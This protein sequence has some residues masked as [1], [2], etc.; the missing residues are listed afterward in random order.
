MPYITNYNY[1]QIVNRFNFYE[2]VLEGDVYDGLIT[3]NTTDPYKTGKENKDWKDIFSKKERNELLCFMRC[4][5]NPREIME[6][7][8]FKKIKERKDSGRYV[9]EEKMPCY[10][11][12]ADCEYL[13]S[14]YENYLLPLEIQEADEEK[15]RAYR[16]WFKQNRYLLDDGEYEKL[17]YRIQM[18]WGINMDLQDLKGLHR[19]N[20]GVRI[21]ENPDLAIIESDIIKLVGEMYD[22][23]MQ[24]VRYRNIIDRYGK[25]TYL[26]D[27][28]QSLEDDRI[29]SYTDD[30]IRYILN[31]FDKKYKQKLTNKLKT[32][33]RVKYNPDLKFEQPLLEEL[34]FRKCYFCEQSLVNK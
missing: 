1:A 32:Y 33:Y 13:N 23:I 11:L 31:E 5:I 15:K 19:D 2:L 16:E 7:G 17:Q 27:K 12:Y 28:K 25:R 6:L 10:H 18:R 30:E 4:L 29:K 34:G 14:P 22:Y 8:V 20:S 26:L 21:M 9:Y 3:F 24:E